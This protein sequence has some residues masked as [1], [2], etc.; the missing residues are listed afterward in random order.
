M[1]V[2]SKK[3]KKARKSLYRILKKV[4]LCS[5]GVEADE[6]P[7]QPELPSDIEDDDISVI[8]LT[9]SIHVTHVSTSVEHGSNKKLDSSSA[10]E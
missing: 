2:L 3:Y 6:L 10:G 7:A 4:F 9:D 8:S 1:A 5:S